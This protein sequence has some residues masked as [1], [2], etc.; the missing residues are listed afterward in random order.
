MRIISALERL[1][2]QPSML[3]N[4][5][6]ALPVDPVNELGRFLSTADL[7]TS[8][9][10]QV[11]PIDHRDLVELRN[12]CQSSDYALSGLKKREIGILLRDEVTVIVPR[13]LANVNAA[14]RTSALRIRIEPLITIYFNRWG[15]SQKEL[16]SLITEALRTYNQSSLLYA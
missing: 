9:T 6:L 2:L 5:F 4:C 1:Q 3:N 7:L 16:E 8:D 11:K 10:R 13:F 12:R 14:I 15:S